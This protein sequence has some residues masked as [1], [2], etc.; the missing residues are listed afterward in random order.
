MLQVSVHCWGQAIHNPS[1]LVT[2]A[3]LGWHSVQTV[4]EVH[5]VHPVGQ[6]TQLFFE[7]R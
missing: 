6:G 5:A 3:Y 2:K 7:S 1:L 4:S